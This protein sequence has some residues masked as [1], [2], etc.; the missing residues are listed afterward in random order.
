MSA[1]EQVRQM[2]DWMRNPTPVRGDKRERVILE[3]GV[4]EGSWPFHTDAE[5]IEKEF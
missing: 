1:F 2:M 4:A 5:Q 3:T